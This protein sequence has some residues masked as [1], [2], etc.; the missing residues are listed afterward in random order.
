MKTSA[1]TAECSGRF[2]LGV[3]WGEGSC[4]YTDGSYYEG[5]FREDLAHGNGL[6]QFANG[7]RYEGQWKEGKRHGEGELKY[8][9][10][11]LYVG[12][13]MYG[14]KNGKGSLR[15]SNGDLYE[16][17]WALGDKSGQG[18]FVTEGGTRYE[19]QWL[20]GMR[21][22][23]GI[24]TSVDGQVF[25]GLFSKNQKNGLGQCSK[26]GETWTC[27]YEKDN[28]IPMSGRPLA[29]QGKL[30]SKL[31]QQYDVINKE[32]V[33]YFEHNFGGDGVYRQAKNSWWQ[34]NTSL[35]N[36]KLTITASSDRYFISIVI[37]KYLGPGTYT[38]GKK[39]GIARVDDS[40]TFYS[41][42]EDPGKVVIVEEVGGL[43]NGFF[44]F[45]AYARG[46]VSAQNV[47]R[48]KNGRFSLKARNP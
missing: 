32:A 1:D 20:N 23:M 6:M 24:L 9:S 7:V 18:I 30:Q 38:V 11:G 3:M 15:Y 27:R 45:N 8:P 44:E 17:G 28:L 29:P 43:I 5:S 40:G 39:S 35:L 41:A 16:G 4:R 12:G 37:E 36:N 31:A 13:W 21:Q 22:G 10:G 33:F 34:K 2:K 25:H 14:L 19:G 42:N 46:K 26:D 47:Y 48:M